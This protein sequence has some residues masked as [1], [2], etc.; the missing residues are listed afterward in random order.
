MS[1][2]RTVAL[3]V[4][5]SGWLAFAAPLHGQ[6]IGQDPV[7]T[8][9]GQAFPTWASYTGSELFVRDGLRCAKPSRDFDSFVPPLAAATAGDCGYFSTNPTSEYAPTFVYDI[10]V[11]VHVIQRTTGVGN[12]SDARIQAQIDVLNEDF[13]A[14]A[15]T[16]AHRATMRGSSSTSRPRT[17]AATRRTASRAP[18]TTRGSTTAASTGTRWP[19][20]RTAT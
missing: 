18:R 6:E 2:P 17:R 11:V 14:L 10:P 3:T 15:G 4:L 13:N 5:A 1:T 16:S 19:G 20:T 7:M 8:V 12:V 9:N